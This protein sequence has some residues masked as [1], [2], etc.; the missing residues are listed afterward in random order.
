MASWS[1]HPHRSRVKV[2]LDAPVTIFAARVNQASFSY[3][4]S[5][6]VFDTVT[7]G[8]YT[9]LERGMTVLFGSSA[10]ADDLG[11]TYIAH[12]IASNGFYIGRSEQGDHDGE[13]NLADNAY[14]TVLDDYRLWAKIPSISSGSGVRLT[15]GYRSFASYGALPPVVILNCGLA[16][17]AD[18]DAGT[19]KATFSFVASSSYAAEPGATISGY[20][21]TLPATG[22]V[23]SGSI[24]THTVS[25]TTDQGV[26]W[27]KLVVTDSNGTTQTRRVKLVAENESNLDGWTL[28]P[29]DLTD[30]GQALTLDLIAPV[31]RSTYP[32]GTML[33]VWHKER[34]GGVAGSLN[35]PTGSKHMLFTGWHDTED[36]SSEATTR[37]VL[38]D[39]TL[40]FVD[41]AGRLKQLMA[42][43]IST[44]NDSS[45][46]SWDEM[47]D[48]NIDKLMIRTAHEYSTLLALC[49]FSWSGTGSSYAFTRWDTSGGSLWDVLTGFAFAMGGG[50]YALTVDEWGRM[51]V[52]VDPMLQDSGSRTATVQQA[53]TEADWV[54]IQAGRDRATKYRFLW[55]KSTVPSTTQASSTKTIPTA[56]AVA[57]GLSGGPGPTEET[58]SG[59]LATSAALVTL[60]KHLYERRS[61]PDT[62]YVIAL[63]HGGNGGISPALKQW[64]TVTQTSDNAA[65]RGDT[66]ATERM[67]PLKVRVEYDGT[68]GLMKRTVTVERETVGVA[69]V[70]FTPKQRIEYALP[71]DLTPPGYDFGGLT[72]VPTTPANAA[73]YAGTARIAAICGGG[74]ALT[75]NFGSGAATDW[76]Y[77]TWASLSATGTPLIWVPH[78]FDPGKGWLITST[79][80]YYGDLATGIFTLKHTFATAETRRHA[81]ADYI[82]AA[83]HLV[84]IS[85]YATGGTKALYTLDNSTF[86][87]V[88]ITTG[89]DATLG[90]SPA[91]V[92]SPHTAGLVYTTAYPASPFASNGY[93]SLDYGQTWASFSNPALTSAH[94]PASSLHLPYQNNS[95][96]S[97]IYYSADDAAPTTY[98]M[99]GAGLTRTNITPSISG[100]LYTPENPL[101]TLVT[102][103]TNRKRGVIVGLKQPAGTTRAV[104]R[105][106]DLDAATPTYTV[107][108]ADGTVYTGAAIAGN[109]QD[110]IY[111]FGTGGSVGLSADAGA[112]IV[113]QSGDLPTF[114]PGTILAIGGY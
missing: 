112:T 15:D 36:A 68:H 46:D 44:G 39:T 12:T 80:V 5:S 10:G 76:S 52:N 33:V 26:R 13:V 86:T 64:V 61:A 85:A 78:G 104:F 97:V 1:D 54:S 49:D 72:P 48:A 60:L 77:A 51:A 87:E 30:E 32:D 109:D 88:V 35:G 111:L 92:V 42:V 114:T 74:L 105:S 101:G 22:V 73:L 37:G 29:W 83:N 6:V 67:L 66:L 20:A 58:V 95:S 106:D 79:K 11:R 19:G 14:I 38:S 91:V 41:V 107:I 94:G 27:L 56:N 31:A 84:V 90:F 70:A 57:P 24:S 81:D 69:A 3:P 34:Y 59:F 53:L 4:L 50:L 7:T 75:E 17:Q 71:R 62:E 99:R 25:F 63:A 113:D 23:V 9:D 45:A 82:F 47:V 103:M 110:V 55:G 40:R 96:D 43:P 102:A 100:T 8:A 21:Y 16:V 65:Q 28:Q 98:V 18:V 93:K 89:S 2:W 108:A